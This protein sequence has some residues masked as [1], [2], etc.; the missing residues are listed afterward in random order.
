LAKINDALTKIDPAH[1]LEYHFLDEQLAR[2]Y[3][4]DHRRETMLIWA[5]LATIFIAC[6]GLFGLATYTAEQRIKE[7]GVRK[8]LGASVVNLTAL[9]SKDFLKLVLIAN[10]IAFPLAW[11]VTGLWLQEFAYHITIEWWIFLVAGG[12]AMFIALLTISYQAIKAALADP[13]KSLKTE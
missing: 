13:V 4:D 8:V 5:A 3:A 2:F 10:G 9:L 11:W 6:L 1:L 7:I 12:S